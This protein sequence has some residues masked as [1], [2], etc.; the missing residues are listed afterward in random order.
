ML[1]AIK[2]L[3]KRTT[4]RLSRAV[5]KLFTTNTTA[6]IATKTKKEEDMENTKTTAITL[7]SATS[8]NLQFFRKDGQ[9]WFAQ[10]DVT[11]INGTNYYPGANIGRPVIV[12]KKDFDYFVNNKRAY[13]G[14][15]YIPEKELVQYIKDRTEV[16]LD[17]RKMHMKGSH[18]VGW[19][20]FAADAIEQLFGLKVPISEVATKALSPSTNPERRK[21]E[22]TLA[23]DSNARRAYV[24]GRRARAYARAITFNMNKQEALLYSVFGKE[25]NDSNRNCNRKGK[26][27]RSL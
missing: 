18:T 11:C 23:N 3:I 20:T 1:Q 6:D 26:G 17:V 13:R 19:S 22:E 8:Y 27:K 14:R 21:V 9:R 10:K 15:V 7:A 25:S 16:A 24:S 5:R 12:S 4:I 2:R